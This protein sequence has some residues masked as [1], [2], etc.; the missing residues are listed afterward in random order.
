MMRL[1]NVQGVRGC[2]RVICFSPK[3][4]LTMAEMSNKEICE[5]VKEWINQME[6]L[7]NFD[8]VNYVQ[9]FENK[10]A[11]MGCSNPHPHGLYHLI[12]GQVWG[13]EDIP[14]EPAA[15]LASLAKY[16][17]KNHSCMLCDLV[18]LE[19]ALKIRVVVEND[20][21]ICI[22]PFWAIWPF[23]TLVLPKTHADSVT[24]LSE[25]QQHGLADILRKITCK[26][27][28]LFRTSF[29]YSMGLHQA[30]LRD[31]SGIMHMH[32]HFYPPLLRS[33]TVKKFIVG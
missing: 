28:N 12:I 7:V 24:K 19:S 11:V 25:G 5:I 2:A 17:A 29:P 1:F 13:T 14:Q 23:E 10:G 8:Y 22:V 4:H 30:P 31:Q 16:H 18:E 33:A 27:D 3:H 15:E 6:D 32:I 26:Y 20:E 21:W 9:L